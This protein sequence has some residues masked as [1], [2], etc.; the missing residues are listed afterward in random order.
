MANRPTVPNWKIENPSTKPNEYSSQ[1]V[2]G[3][4]R[5]T[6]VTD[7]STGQRSLYS[8]SGTG[9][10]ETKTLISTT[11]SN[12]DVIRGPGY[13]AVSSN[14]ATLN[15][16]NKSQSEFIMARTS[17]REEKQELGKTTEYKNK[18]GLQEGGKEEIVAK[19]G[20][21]DNNLPDTGLYP[22]IE[23]GKIVTYPID[24]NV[25]QDRIVFTAV[26]MMPR[27]DF[28][29]DNIGNIG[30]L[31]DNNSLSEEKL[32][33]F[34][35]SDP[36]YEEVGG[37]VML[38]IQAPIQDQNAAEWT[39]DSITAVQA[40]LYNTATSLIGQDKKL[41][42]IGTQAREG[43]ETN[44]GR[45]QRMFAGEAAGINNILSRTDGTVLNP[46]LELIFQGPQLRAFS[47]TFKLSARSSAEAKVI[48]SIIK[49]F[50][51]HMAV[52]RDKGLFLKAPHVFTI[53]YKRGSSND[54]H[55]G[56]NMI[57]PSYT[58]R[59]CALTNMS[60]DYTSLG[61]YMTFEDGTMVTYTISLQFQDIQPIY[62][63]DYNND[64]PI[65]Y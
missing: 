42:D 60:T 12:G 30:T 44:V 50:K 54:S 1:F 58:K 59:G 16:A 19:I 20:E 62:A 27:T 15:S 7:V 29:S 63:E 8:V 32:D 55:P 17:T 43:A 52:R 38:P 2:S 4:S 5:Y 36:I 51:R 53:M 35:I 23:K 13:T 34:N 48:L 22:V 33:A 49:Y 47:F 31:G 65:G 10:N 61:S 3:G 21:Q 40:L 46:N 64:H 57:S 39:S 9:Q 18:F 56:I 45:L 24:M 37:H 14:Y 6:N 26:Q 25:D 41:G 11:S 28:G